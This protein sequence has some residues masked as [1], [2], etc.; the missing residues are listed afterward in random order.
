MMCFFCK[1][2]YIEFFL[3]PNND[4]RCLPCFTL[5]EHHLENYNPEDLEEM[6]NKFKAKRRKKEHTRKWHSESADPAK[7]LD[8]SLAKQTNK[9]TKKKLCRHRGP[10]FR[11][12]RL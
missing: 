6:A 1:N 5:M 9:Q 10:N 12:S 7:A 2:V 8:L 3:K 4:P 11:P